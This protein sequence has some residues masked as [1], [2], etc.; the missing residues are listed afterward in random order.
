MGSVAE[1][2]AIVKSLLAAVRA[3]PAPPTEFLGCGGLEGLSLPR[4]EEPASPSSSPS[5]SALLPLARLSFSSSFPPLSA[6]LVVGADGARSAV[7]ALSGIRDS[8]WGRDY[9]AAA[10]VATVRLEE[11]GGEERGESGFGGNGGESEESDVGSSRPSTSAS[12]S[13]SPG[14]PHRAKRNVAWQRF[15]S[16]GPLAL[17]PLRDSYWSVVWSTTPQHARE[18][19]EAGARS[20][21]EF[22][23]AVDRALRRSGEG[24]EARGGE[25]TAPPPPPPPHRCRRRRPSLLP[26]RVLPAP[27][28]PDPRSFPLR[29][30]SAGTFVLP[31]LALVGDAAHSV[32]PLGGQGVNLGLGDASRLASFLA[33]AASVGADPG[34]DVTALERGYGGPRRLATEAM[35]AALDGLQRVF[36]PQ[37]GALAEARAAALAG[38][39]GS[40]PLRSA[41]VRY[42]MGL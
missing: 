25:E 32:H 34:A 26:A 35:G 17:L 5:S 3:S 7:R 22:A 23:A 40:G 11:G 6:R 38:I 42:A 37:R 31:R 2:E 27:G 24:E 39:D 41:I 19:S 12:A 28:A 10:V 21:E 16:T 8:P 15:L 29:R 4:E 30:S 20:P 18:L 9:A 36:G 33:E 14:E 1:N 13:S